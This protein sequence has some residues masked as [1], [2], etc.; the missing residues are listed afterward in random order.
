MASSTTARIDELNTWIHRL[1]DASGALSAQF[2]H[3]GDNMITKNAT[4]QGFH[5]EMAM[6]AVNYIDF[7]QVVSEMLEVADRVDELEQDLAQIVDNLG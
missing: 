7:L 2:V 4:V 6:R 1:A 5:V 3:L